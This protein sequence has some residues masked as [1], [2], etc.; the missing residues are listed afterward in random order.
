ML[1]K[2]EGKAKSITISIEASI[3]II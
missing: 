1:T 2:R 3:S